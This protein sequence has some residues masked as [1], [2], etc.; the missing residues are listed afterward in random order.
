MDR[1][2]DQV[3]MPLFLGP[4]GGSGAGLF[5]ARGIGAQGE[6]QPVTG[7]QIGG[8]RLDL[9]RLE[10]RAGIRGA[11]RQGD[12]TALALGP[13]QEIARGRRIAGKGRPDQP[14]MGVALRAVAR[15]VQQ[16]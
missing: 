3:D 13:P 4:A 14:V 16:R 2:H 8:E 9:G 1:I 11:P 7:P 12:E 5:G 10:Q 6:S 15:R